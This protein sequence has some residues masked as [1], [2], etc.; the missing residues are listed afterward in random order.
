MG[1]GGSDAHAIIE[2]DFHNESG[3]IDE[4][5]ESCAKSVEYNMT[6]SDVFWS[7][8][9]DICYCVRFGS[10]C[11]HKETDEEN[12]NVF[13]ILERDVTCR[14]S[15]TYFEGNCYRKFDNPVFWP[16]A[17]DFCDNFGVGG[18]R[19]ELAV[20]VKEEINDLVMELIGSNPRRESYW[21]GGQF[22]DGRKEWVW[23]DDEVTDW[24]H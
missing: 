9:R 5:Y 4:G 23:D 21:I 7:N 1:H 19:G 20:V 22:F 15:W 14:H 17:E 13:V 8:G 24:E 12:M 10:I 6:C 18:K 11:H 2:L 3:T 16:V